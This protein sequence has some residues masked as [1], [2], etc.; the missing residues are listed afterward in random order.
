[1]LTSKD[2]QEAIVAQTAC[3]LSGV[4]RAFS[5]MLDKIW[6]DAREQGR[7]TGYV[8]EHPICK[9]FADKI[10]DLAKVRSFEEYS[11]AYQQCRELVD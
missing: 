3:N 8:N 6:Q 9:L 10:A 4:V 7:G 11:K 2:Y 5:R 1:M